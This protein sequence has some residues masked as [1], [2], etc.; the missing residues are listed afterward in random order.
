M[1][2]VLANQRF[3]ETE[4]GERGFFSVPD[5]MLMQIVK[6]SHWQLVSGLLY[7]CGK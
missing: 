6:R 1:S 7:I 2:N 3:S 4:N 5:R